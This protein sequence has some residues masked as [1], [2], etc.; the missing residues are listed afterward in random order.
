MDLFFRY[1]TFS[2]IAHSRVQWVTCTEQADIRAQQRPCAN[3]HQAGVGDDTI[4]VNIDVCS[5]F[6][7]EPVP[8]FDGVSYPKFI[9]EKDSSSAESSCGRG[10]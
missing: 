8:N 5:Q 2:P 7:V 10:R 9:L 3:R 1:R 4:S 6:H